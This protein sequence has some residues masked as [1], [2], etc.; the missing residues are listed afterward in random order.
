[1]SKIYPLD[2]IKTHAPSKYFYDEWSERKKLLFAF[3]IAFSV[4]VVVMLFFLIFV[5]SSILIAGVLDINN[6]DMN[7]TDTYFPSPVPTNLFEITKSD[8]HCI[9]KLDL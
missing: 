4:S 7:K 8:N 2:Y 6:S 9:D 1:M 5:L 3:F